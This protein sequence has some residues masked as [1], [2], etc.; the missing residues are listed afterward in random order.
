MKELIRLIA[1]ATYKG[2]MQKHSIILSLIHIFNPISNAIL[3]II[4]GVLK[5]DL[6]LD[7]FLFISFILH[8]LAV[9]ILYKKYSCLIKHIDRSSLMKI[10]KVRREMNGFGY[11]GLVLLNVIIGIMLAGYSHKIIKFVSAMLYN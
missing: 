10:S 2:K 3:L 1:I 8:A 7:L 11:I 4:L 9:F 5:I 6:G